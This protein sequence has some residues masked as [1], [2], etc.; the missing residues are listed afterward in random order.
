MTTHCQVVFS[1]C[2]TQQSAEEM[3]QHLIE[4]R[5]AACVNILPNLKSI[6]RWQGNIETATEF[7]MII[8]TSS[9]NYQKL[10]EV[11]RKIHPYNTPEIIALPISQ[12]LPDYLQWV[13]NNTG[14]Q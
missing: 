8:K 9:D 6:Y 13:V 12:A 1:T 2:P 4:L 10:E 7:L 14:M 11:L 3:A 5:L